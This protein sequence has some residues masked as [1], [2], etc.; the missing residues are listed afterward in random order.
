VQVHLSP[1]ARAHE[2]PP[3]A[4]R[5]PTVRPARP[6]SHPGSTQRAT[7]ARSASA[8]GPRRDAPPRS[9][10]AWPDRSASPRRACMRRRNERIELGF[11][12]AAPSSIGGGSEGS[13]AASDGGDDDDG[14]RARPTA[15]ARG[16]VKRRPRGPAG[17]PAGAR[18]DTP[19]CAHQ[20]TV[21]TPPAWATAYCHFPGRPASAAISRRGPRTWQSAGVA[22]SQC[23]RGPAASKLPSPPAQPAWRFVPSRRGVA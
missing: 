19:T 7:Q 1:P 20:R 11:G 14:V 8:S 17:R 15:D 9:G 6:L 12:P 3:G 13:V 23:G 22:E 2:Q 16:H 18:G 4:Q 21:T 10:R 5:D